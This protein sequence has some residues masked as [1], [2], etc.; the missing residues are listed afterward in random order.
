[1]PDQ[2]AAAAYPRPLRLLTGLVLRYMH[3]SDHSDVWLRRFRFRRPSSY[4]IL[5][6][7]RFVLIRCLVVDID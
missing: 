1:M 7:F 4:C 6:S 5:G 2:C 3:L